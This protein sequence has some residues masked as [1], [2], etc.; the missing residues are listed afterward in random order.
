MKNK[1]LLSGIVFFLFISLLSCKKDNHQDE[2][3][4]PEEPSW[5]EVT[6]LSGGTFIEI[7]SEGNKIYAVGADGYLYISSDYGNTWSKGE[8]IA[9]GGSLINEIFVKN[10]LLLIGTMP[11]YSGGYTLFK[12]TDDGHTWNPANNGIPLYNAVYCLLQTNDTMYSAGANGIYISLDSGN[13]W[14]D[15]TSNLSPTNIISLAKNNNTLFI[16]ESNSLSYR[17]SKS[18]S[19]GTSWTSVYT[20]PSPIYTLLTDGNDIYAGT[21]NGVVH[22]AD[23]GIN[24]STSGMTGKGILCLF[25]SGTKLFAGTSLN[26]LYESTNGGGSWTVVSGGIPV[27]TSVYNLALEGSKLFAGTWTEGI[28]SSTDNGNNWIKGNTRMRI[29][30]LVGAS[31]E[32]YASISGGGIY[33]SADGG[34]TWATMNSGF[35]ADI[36]I[37]SLTYANG[38]IYASTSLGVYTTVVGGGNWNTNGPLATLHCVSVNGSNILAGTE[39][40]GIRVS[41]NAGSSWSE[42]LTG[43]SSSGTVYSVYAGNGFMLAGEA[44]TGVYK[45]VDNGMNW[46]LIP[47]MNLNYTYSFLEH[48]SKLFAA[49]NLGVFSSSDGGNTWSAANTGLDIYWPYKSLIS[50]GT[51]MFVVNNLYGVYYSADHGNSW[52]SSSNNLQ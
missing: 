9:V 31:N 45:S 32:V 46:S 34:N 21:G 52:K 3:P 11:S 12:S 15:I 25:K 29:N 41:S 4:I 1:S 35:A 36:Q 39:Q 38:L 27:N 30:A 13:N 14:S 16:G 24:W 18:N 23:N 51:N 44:G 6:S 40:A 7:C 43:I 22:S 50:D 33:K 37:N 47:D 17:I 5:S 8:S 48:N 2:I 10:G 20:S 49:T 26:G 42:A 28:F 19:N